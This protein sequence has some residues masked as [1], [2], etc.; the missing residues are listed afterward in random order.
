MKSVIIG[1]EKGN[2]GSSTMHGLFH[3]NLH[4]VKEKVC[5][6]KNFF[7]FEKFFKYSK[8]S[9]RTCSLAAWLVF[10]LLGVM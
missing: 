5:D 10:R 9:V 8:I 2:I 4:L 3:I 7:L 6:V 1:G